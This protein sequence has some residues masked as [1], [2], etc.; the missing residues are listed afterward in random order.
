MYGRVKPQ[1]SLHDVGSFFN[2]KLPESSFYGQLVSARDR[3]FQDE[4]FA[5]LYK[6][7]N[8]GRPSVPPSRLALVVIMQARDGISDAEAIERTACDLRW[9]LVRSE[10]HTS[11]LQSRG[12]L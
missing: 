5:E 9:N 1:L 10:E 4:D 6:G 3:L 12:H 11:E 8:N 7:S 2:M